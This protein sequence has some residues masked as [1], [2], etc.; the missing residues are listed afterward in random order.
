MTPGF[1]IAAA[2]AGVALIIAAIAWARK[3][4]GIPGA[5]LL[6][7]AGLVWARVC[8]ALLPPD[9][10]LL[11]LA[12]GW[13]FVGGIIMRHASIG[14]SHPRMWCGALLIASG[15]CYAVAEG[16]STGSAV[17]ALPLM[18]SD[19]LGIAALAAL[20]WGA[21]YGSRVGDYQGSGLG[22]YRLRGRVL[23]GGFLAMASKKEGRR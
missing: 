22:R 8:K 6:I 20:F 19:A 5:A 3:A 13:V 12:A 21:I 15:L 17:F 9:M 23:A 11:A 18:V 4:R 14:Q 2:Y 7:V 10:H 1:A 16:F